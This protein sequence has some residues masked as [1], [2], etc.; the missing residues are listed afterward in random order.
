M[1]WYVFVILFTRRY[2][3]QA[4]SITEREEDEK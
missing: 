1:E 3:Q 4:K 2:K